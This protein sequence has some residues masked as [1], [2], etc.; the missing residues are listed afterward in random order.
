MATMPR[1]IAILGMEPDQIDPES[2]A[3]PLAKHRD[4]YVGNAVDIGPRTM[5][6]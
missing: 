2:G 1:H 3:R 5:G 6:D 4:R